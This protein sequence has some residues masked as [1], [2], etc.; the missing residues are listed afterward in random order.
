[1]D[2]N[3]STL[4]RAGADAVLSYA[5]TGANAIWNHLSADNT[6]QLAEGLDVFR[7]PVPGELTGQ[8]L[9][10]CRIRQETGCTVVAVVDDGR[11]EPN[12]PAVRVLPSGGD[13]V[14]IGDSESEDRFL[15]RY[16]SGASPVLP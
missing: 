5:S 13:L 3:V 14:L 11:F 1:L 15:H 6:L 7:V 2:R 10:Q 9:E 16:R 12:P 8:S 4:H